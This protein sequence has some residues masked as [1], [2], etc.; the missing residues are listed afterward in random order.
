MF[1]YAFLDFNNMDNL[2]HYCTVKSFESIISS[3]SIWLSSLTLSNDAM[4][5]KLVSHTF[6]ILLSQSD[7]GEIEANE[8]RKA[9]SFVESV[10]DGLGFCLSEKSD[11]LSQWRGYANDGQGFCIGFDKDYLDEL[12]KVKEKGRSGFSIEQVL[13]E[14]DEHLNALR[15]TFEEIKGILDAGKLKKPQFGLLRM[16]LDGE[17]SKGHE[18]Y[19]EILRSIWN[20]ISKTYRNIFVL[21][22]RAFS[23]EAEWRLISYLEKSSEDHALFRAASNR[24]IPYRQFELK[25]LEINPIN[26][27]YVGPKNI[28]PDFVI[29]NFLQRNG[30]EGVEIERSSATYR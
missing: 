28:T 25:S 2:Y 7:I 10:F 20:K 18:E 19:E 26:K 6:D 30:F 23:E 27:I 4:E 15:L 3:K 21:K 24:L 13:Y 12:S 11:L 17:I 22:N 29:E 9:I 8:I 16:P 1:S 14:P 5:G